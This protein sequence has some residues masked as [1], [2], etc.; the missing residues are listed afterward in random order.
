MDLRDRVVAACDS[1]ELT[2]Q[3]VAEEF[4]VSTAW[5]RR[6]LQRRQEVGTY[7]PKEHAGGHPPAFDH[8]ELKRLDR[9]LQEQPDATLAELRLRSGVKCSLTAVSNALERLG[10]RRKKRRSGQPNKIDLM[11]F[12]PVGFGGRNSLIRTGVVFASSTKAVQKRI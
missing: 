2:R 5:I 7:Q 4:G 8:A 6:L 3:E 1:E 9:L 10:Y 12:E 11:S